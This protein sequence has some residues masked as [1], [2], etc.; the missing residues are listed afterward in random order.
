MGK[1][2]YNQHLFYQPEGGDWYSFKNSVFLIILQYGNVQ[3][4]RHVQY[5]VIRMQLS[6][7]K[8]AFYVHNF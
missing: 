4:I 1:T 5:T 6:D 8:Y 7:F 3:N 2:V